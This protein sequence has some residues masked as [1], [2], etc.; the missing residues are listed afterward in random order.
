MFSRRWCCRLT[1]AASTY[2][3]ESG[4]DFAVGSEITSIEASK[5][6]SSSFFSWKTTMLSGSKKC[7]TSQRCSTLSSQLTLM[8]FS[9]ASNFL[10]RYARCQ[11]C[12]ASRCQSWDSSASK[13]F[14]CT[15]RAIKQRGCINWVIIIFFVWTSKVS[16]YAI[17]NQRAQDASKKSENLVRVPTLSRRHFIARASINS[18]YDYTII[19]FSLHCVKPMI[20]WGKFIS[21]ITCDRFFFFTLSGRR[22]GDYTFFA[23]KCH[24][25]AN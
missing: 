23:L 19:I 5:T 25:E 16:L 2:E 11:R 1:M 20:E 13:T 3:T 24:S 7:I 14:S 17:Y 8:T 10:L 22:M 15:R 4:I 18:P 21:F 12:D 6:S 9:Y